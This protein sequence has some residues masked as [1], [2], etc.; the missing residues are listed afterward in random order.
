[1]S[2]I[3]I[4]EQLAEEYGLVIRGGF[5]VQAD[6]AVPDLADGDRP[7]TLVLFGNAGSS[8]WQAFS[9]STEISDGDPDSLDRWSERIGSRMAKKLGGL[10]LFPFG[11]P[12][13]QP[14]TQWAKRAESLVGSK[15]GM[16]IHPRYGLWHAYRFAIAFPVAIDA[17]SHAPEVTDVCAS[18]QDQPCLSRCPVEAFSGHSYDVESCYHYLHS[19]PDSSCRTR[20]CEARMACPQGIS[21]QYSPEHARFHM[22]AFYRNVNGRFGQKK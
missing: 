1:M 18:C 15:L 13:Y 17:F 19:N 20:T 10:A 3:E 7:Q 8:L 6:D 2:S 22:D 4:I 9:A 5:R 21:F 14:F 16:L 12:P 11:G